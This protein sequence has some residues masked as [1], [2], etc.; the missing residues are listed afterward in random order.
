MHLAKFEAASQVFQ[1][2]ALTDLI[3]LD[4]GTGSRLI[5]DAQM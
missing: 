5:A 1:S 4:I 3:N 2:C